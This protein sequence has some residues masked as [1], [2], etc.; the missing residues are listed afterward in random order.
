MTLECPVKPFVAWV[1]ATVNDSTGQNLLYE[2]IPLDWLRTEWKGPGNNFRNVLFLSDLPQGSYN[3]D[4]YIWN[5][6]KV[7][8]RVSRSEERR[9][10]KECRS[11]WSPHH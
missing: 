3:L 1:V 11:R 10:G 4:T 7:P 8:Y 9:V 2:R 5:M 6:D